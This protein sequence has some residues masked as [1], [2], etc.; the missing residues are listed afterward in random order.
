MSA[1]TTELVATAYM[2]DRELFHCVGLLAL[3]GVFG[4]RCA[5]GAK[6]IPLVEGVTE[7]T[8]YY[9]SKAC[10][11]DAPKR[12]AE[13]DAAW[14]ATVKKI[15]LDMS[16]AELATDAAYRGR[17]YKRHKWKEI[18]ADYGANNHALWRLTP[19][20]DPRKRDDILWIASGTQL[21]CG[22]VRPEDISDEELAEC[23]EIDYDRQNYDRGKYKAT[24]GGHCARCGL[25]HD[26][27][28]DIDCPLFRIMV[29]FGRDLVERIDLAVKKA[30]Q[31]GKPGRP[32][33]YADNAARKRAER[34]RKRKEGISGRCPIGVEPWMTVFT[35]KRSRVNRGQFLT[36]ALKGAGKT[37]QILE[38][39][40]DEDET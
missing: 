33:K 40:N 20:E 3:C 38:R 2:S 26:E 27:P 1:L 39:N 32:R 17:K 34:A 12:T 24:T 28:L 13:E 23:P 8:R 16:K 6:P 11:K 31:R 22:A 4:A 9:C 29:K 36:D 14:I 37:L 30:V 5:C 18:V 21:P 10:A 7:Q 25:V 35:D 15:E 19:D